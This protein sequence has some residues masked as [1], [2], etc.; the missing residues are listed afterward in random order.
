MSDNNTPVIENQANSAPIESNEG[1]N[2]QEGSSEQNLS[3]A[4]IE[5]KKIDDV[6]KAVEA[7]KN[8]RKLKLKID[9]KDVEEEIDLNNDQ[10]LAKHLQLSKVAQKRM[11]ESAEERKKI[12]YIL[13]NLQKNPEEVMRQL[14]LDPEDFAVQLLN[15]KIAD[16]QK[17]P[18]QRM[19]EQLQKEVEEAKRQRE[20]ENNTRRDAEIKRYQKEF[21]HKLEDGIIGALK[22]ANLPNK[23]YVVKRFAENM[24]IALEQGI[25]L[26]VRDLTPLVKRDLEND[27]KELFAAS[28]DEFI[29]EMIGKDR[30]NNMRKKQ[31]ASVKKNVESVNQIKQTGDSLKAKQNSEETNKNK[32]KISMSDFLKN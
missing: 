1:S 12:E 9:G 29:S 14:G 19:I 18:E 17:S 7:Q 11:Q 25:N 5:T 31:V 28:P 2:D 16:N 4:P 27:I 8:I 22:E 3:A 13:Q 30:F 32:Q 26:E 24:L 20:E 21:E 6:K 10:E 15:K 23:P